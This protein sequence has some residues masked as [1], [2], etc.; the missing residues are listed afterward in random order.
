MNHKQPKASYSC[1]PASS[2]FCNLI[3][4]ARL[5]HDYK[6]GKT[7]Y[8]GSVCVSVCF[9]FILWGEGILTQA[10]FSLS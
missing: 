2:G 4:E 1:L 5:N 6:H 10:S 8:L 9:L 7:F 3:Y